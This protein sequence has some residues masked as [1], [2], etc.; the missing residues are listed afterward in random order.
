MIAMDQPHEN[1]IMVLVHACS[2]MSAEERDKFL[3]IE[4]AGDPELRREVE[5][6]IG[7]GIAKT[8]FHTVAAHLEKNL[9]GHY[10][11]TRLLGIGGMAEVFL[12]E[13]TRLGRRVAIKFLN[14]TFKTDPERMRR[15]DLEA[16]ST[17]AMNH[18]HIL[19]IYDIGEADGGQYIVNEYVDV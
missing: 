15:F 12:A 2:D 6:L 4:C 14:E 11:L 18:P 19:T 1:R 10:R 9:P 16:R 13:D 8:S 3:S 17:S 5:S 7:E